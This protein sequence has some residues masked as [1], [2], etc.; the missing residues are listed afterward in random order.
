MYRRH[1]AFI[2]KTVS[3]SKHPLIVANISAGDQKRVAVVIH[4]RF[5][6][7]VQVCT[8][9]PVQPIII[10]AAIVISSI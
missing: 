3:H 9:F 1:F 2:G 6:N 7:I 8:F 10:R 4:S 5:G